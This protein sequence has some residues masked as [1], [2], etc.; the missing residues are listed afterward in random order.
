[1]AKLTKLRLLLRRLDGN[2]SCECF[3]WEYKSVEIEVALD[4][5]VFGSY[6]GQWEV[7]G[8]ERLEEAPND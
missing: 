6:T 4:D 1:M 7:Y 8:A 3:S 2:P 5:A